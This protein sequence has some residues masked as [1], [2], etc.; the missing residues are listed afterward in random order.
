MRLHIFTTTY[1]SSFY[2]IRRF[3]AT[4]IFLSLIYLSLSHSIHPSILVFF[5]LFSPPFCVVVCSFVCFLS[6]RKKSK[7]CTLP[8]GGTPQGDLDMAGDFRLTCS[9]CRQRIEMSG[10]Q[11]VKCTGC[12]SVFCTKQCLRKSMKLKESEPGEK[13]RLAHLKVCNFERDYLEFM[14]VNAGLIEAWRMYLQHPPKDDPSRAS[15]NGIL[16]QVNVEEDTVIAKPL[17]SIQLVQQV[18]RISE[19]SWCEMRAAGYP[20]VFSVFVEYN[21]ILHAFEIDAVI[22]QEMGSFVRQFVHSEPWLN[23]CAEWFITPKEIQNNALCISENKVEGIIDSPSKIKAAEL[24]TSSQEGR[25]YVPHGSF[26]VW[27]MCREKGLD[28]QSMQRKD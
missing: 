18:A 4:A 26:P 14:K 27:K 17:N 21:A 6:C 22:D 12:Q 20:E 9:G 13:G 25:H 3:L 11:D 1:C 23:R 19:P 24:Q 10:K 2:C 16:I 8:L 15:F 28:L 7:L 5:L